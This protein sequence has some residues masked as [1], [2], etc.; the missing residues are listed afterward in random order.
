MRPDND[1]IAWNRAQNDLDPFTYVRWEEMDEQELKPVLVEAIKAVSALGLD[2]GGVDVM[3][4]DNVAYVLEV[5]TAPTLN[6]SPYVAKK[7]GM[8]FDWLFKEETRRP[9]WENI[10][11]KRHAKSMVFKNY[12]LRDE[13]TN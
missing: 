5:N 10:I 7:Y 2:F 12:Q 8:Y 6:T 13:E 1:N 4:K 3:F 11:D 9:H